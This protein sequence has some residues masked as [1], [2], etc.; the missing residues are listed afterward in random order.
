MGKKDFI[1]PPLNEKDIESNYRSFDK[2]C[3][4]ELKSSVTVAQIVGTPS[5]SPKYCLRLDVNEF[6][7]TYEQ[8]IDILK[9]ADRLAGVNRKFG[10]YHLWVS[11]GESD[12]S[13][14]VQAIYVGKG[15]IKKRVRNHIKNYLDEQ[16]TIFITFYECENRIAKYLEQLFLDQ[17]LFPLNT[18]ENLGKDLLYTRWEW[19]IGREGTEADYMATLFAIAKESLEK[20][21]RRQK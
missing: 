21:R 6:W 5:N 19:L 11:H 18:Q 4:A 15:H 7:D 13:R 3:A 16:G 20:A 12:E 2:A 10:L 14:V 8:G 9:M 1:C 17:F